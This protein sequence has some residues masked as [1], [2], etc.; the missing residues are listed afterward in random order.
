MNALHIAAFN[1]HLDVT[2]YLISRGAEAKKGDNDGKTAL[3]L[4]A[5]KSH[6]D[7]IKYLI[8]QGADVNKVA[9]DADAKKGDNDGKTALHIA[10]QEGH[11][12]VTKY[13]ISQGVEAKKGDNDGKTALHI[14]AQEAEA[15]KGDNDG[16]TA[17]HIAAQEGHIDVTKYLI[18]QGAEVNMGDRNDGYTPMHIAA[19]KDDLD[20]VKVLLEE[21]ALVDVRDANG[22]TPLHLSSKKGSANFCD[23][24]A[25]H[26]KINGL[27]DHSDDEGLT[28]IH[29]ATQ[30]GHTSV[31]ESLV[32]QGSSLNIQS[33]DGKTCLHEA[34]I[35]SDHMSRKEE[36]KSNPQQISEDFY[37]QELFRKKVAL[38]LY[39]LEHGG[40]MDIRDVKGKLQS[41]MAPM[42]YPTDDILKV[43][44]D[45]DDHNI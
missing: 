24:L 26:A 18:N 7:V 3:H 27:L 40:K 37:R 2:K 39:I 17:L 29:I 42:N 14:A 4:A 43:T 19:S 30:N 20:I 22:Q 34:I 6:L 12:D 9:N 45:R 36:T 23:F 41:T 1:G 38:V 31:V 35:L 32:S 15:K 11:T 33:H 21:G 13:L 8:S 28:A 10:A 25:E 16:K 44:V 5:I